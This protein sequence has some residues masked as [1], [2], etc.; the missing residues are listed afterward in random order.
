MATPYIGT[1]EDR[2]VTLINDDNDSALVL[3]TDFT[4]GSPT[5]IVGD[6]DNYNTKLTLIAPE[7]SEAVDTQIKYNRL[8]LSDV[9]DALEEGGDSFEIDAFPFSIRESLPLLNTQFGLELTEDEVEDTVYTEATGDGNYQI[10]IA[11]GSL[12]WIP[13][14]S[15]TFVGVPPV[16]PEPPEEP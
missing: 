10:T 8:P 12:A 16:E 3:G 9:L 13:A 5:A 4:F 7:E 1:S 11:D 6:P 15:M 14:S 2:L